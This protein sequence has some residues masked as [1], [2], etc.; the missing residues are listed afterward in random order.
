MISNMFKKISASTLVTLIAAVAIPFNASAI[1][2]GTDSVANDFTVLIVAEKS[3]TKVGICSGALLN[4][5]VVVTAAHCLSD[6]IGL[7]SKRILVAPPGTNIERSSEGNLIPKSNWVEAD[8]TSV[9][10]TYQSGS[11]RVTND[12]LAFLTLKNPLQSNPL[13]KIASEDEMLKLKSSS[14]PLKIYGYGYLSNAGNFPSAPKYLNAEFENRTVSLANSGIAKSVSSAVCSGDSGGPVVNVTP[15]AITVV[16][17]TTGAAIT[18]KCA[19]KDFDGVYRSSFT[20]L[21]R[22][23]NLAFS[24]VSKIASNL[25]AASISQSDL[26]VAKSRIS[27]LEAEV[28][29]WASDYADLELEMDNLKT[30]IESLKAKLPKTITCMKGAVTKK[31][32]AV[33]AKCPTGFKIKN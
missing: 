8:S 19:N 5:Y 14:S 11:T 4:D 28:E 21:N 29:K 18:N 12:D 30:E 27:E 32:T 2:N 22:Y 9:T 26:D 13:V 16:G 17:V 20:L 6:D 10:L 7:I 23:A 15:T 25:N 24:T 31:I 1:E 33:N 3:G